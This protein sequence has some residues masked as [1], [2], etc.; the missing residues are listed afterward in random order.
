M[1]T[2]RD[3]SLL[4]V[5]SAV[6]V[7]LLIGALIVQHFRHGWPFSLHHGLPVQST[8]AAPLVGPPGKSETQAPRT[9][10]ELDPSRL[11]AI[12]VRFERVRK[13]SMGEPLRAIA[14]IVPDE[15]RVSHVHTRV[16]GWIEKL[17]INTTG[18]AVRAGQPLAGIFSQELLS[19]Q[20]EY[21][22]AKR[23]ATQGPASA[24]LE[25]SRAR[26]KVF[27]MTDE[28]IRTLDREGTPR[29]LVNVT[30][31]RS[32][33]VL[34]RGIT[35]GTAVDPSTELL[36][37]A[38]LSHVW[39]L[40]EIP[41]ANIAGIER[42]TPANID[43]SGAG[44]APFESRVA[45]VYPTLSE[46][47]RTLR[48]RFDAPNRDGKLRP[49]IY[50]SVVF[51][52]A[53]RDALVVSRDAV[54]DTGEMQHVFVVEH[55]KHFVPRMVTLG[56]RL[57]DRVEVTSGLSEGEEVVS[58]GVFLID[59]ESR[60]RA[61]GG[62]G[63]GHVHGA[64]S[65]TPPAAT[66]AQPAAPKAPGEPDHGAHLKPTPKR[67]PPASEQPSSPT[68]PAPPSAPPPSVDHGAHTGH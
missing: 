4:G 67:A 25:A 38:D 36:T 19:S 64:A 48:V 50:G 1:S 49:G 33:V 20:T 41:E 59:S 29:R 14:T 44:R 28:D 65:G 45:F 13:E 55:G 61:S 52:L 27:G 43:F 47:T 6:A 30:A 60:L 63:T 51:S 17:Y 46:R 66:P 58:S 54:V 39:V 26:L 68:P 37:V 42:G 34:H 9:T 22:A 7:A 18:Q 5:G 40:A 24:V 62:A 31:P 16:A 10:V 21:L 23:A 15:T 2:R 35:V 3:V 12:G 32:G 8:T 53:P 56:M 11:D 57:E